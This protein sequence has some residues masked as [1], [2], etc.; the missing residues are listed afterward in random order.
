M[1]CRLV[2]ALFL[3]V[4]AAAAAQHSLVSS[5]VSPPRQSTPCTRQQQA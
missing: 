3:G 4:P 1:I 2:V 5:Y